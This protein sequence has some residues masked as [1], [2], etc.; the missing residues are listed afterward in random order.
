MTS[1]R[2][3]VCP[4]HLAGNRIIAHSSHDAPESPRRFA[5]MPDFVSPDQIR[6]RFADDKRVL[7]ELEGAVV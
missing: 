6:A 7:S 3:I 1:G 2:N 5:A 4:P